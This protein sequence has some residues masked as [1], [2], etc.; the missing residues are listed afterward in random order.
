MT[1][2]KYIVCL[3][4]VLFGSAA[5]GQRTHTE[6]IL[7]FHSDIDIATDGTVTV[8]EHIRVY[9]G[10]YQIK[11]G[12][13][14]RIPITRVDTYGKKQPV[15]IQV[16]S[17]RCDGNRTDYRNEQE[18]DMRVI[19]VG[20]KDV[21]L[22]PG[23]YE[24][25]LTYSSRG[26]VGFFDNFDELYWNVTGND[27]DFAIDEASATIT[28]PPGA[29][30]LSTDCYTGAYGR[31][32]K[33]CE[34]DSK[35]NVVN[36][37][38][39]ASLLRG[40]GLTVAV[41][42]PRGIIERPA[43]P[44]AW[45]LFWEKYRRPLSAGISL[46]LL[47]AYCWFSWNKAGRDPRRPVVIPHFRPPHDWSPAVIRYLYKRISDD[48]AF[49]AALVSMAVK[50]AIRIEL[51]KK[52]YTL[53]AIERV[54]SLSKEE[55]A[56]YSALFSKGK[57]LTVSDKNHARFSDATL[58]L[59]EALSLVINMKDYHTNNLGYIGMATLVCPGV[60]AL[61]LLLNQPV[62]A[63][64]IFSPLFLG[65]GVLVFIIYCFYIW[66]IQAPTLLGAK[67]S[68][69]LEGFKMYL[70]TAEEH[71]LNLLTPPE[72]TPEL[73]ERMLPYAIALNVEN[74]WG[75]KF[76]SVLKQYNYSPDWYTGT[77]PLVYVALA[78]SFA[79]SV[80]Q[81]RIDPTASSSSSSSSSSS[82]G[83]WSSGSG[84]GGFSGGGGGGGGGGGW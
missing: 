1:M 61:Y 6:R 78:S 40:E 18:G 5:Y 47:L 12:I 16:I 39:T 69:E 59:S 38:T 72:Q 50:K 35:D 81:A 26:H 82:G 36:F 56:L 74:E 43:P 15:D 17:V 31:A 21:I 8:T 44:S 37:R 28:L 54:E 83:S 3:I 33:D 10:G 23:E 2:K 29:S 51:V 27:W 25:T 9:A 68:A 60:M 73:F 75:S 77:E 57:T 14:R 32:G 48:R 49:T 20:N 22:S 34:I 76:E 11:R 52:K 64:V 84:G 30:A 55:A 24:Y 53:H 67:T 45:E 63:D 46:L 65:L 71:R 13:V 42:F 4:L 66:L 7:S 62:T 79:S 80:S 19:Y 58:E 41:S 70:K